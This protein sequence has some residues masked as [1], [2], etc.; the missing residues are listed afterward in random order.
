M[1]G[2]RMGYNNVRALLVAQPSIEVTPAGAFRVLVL[3]A[4]FTRDGDNPPQYWAGVSWLMLNMPGETGPGKRRLMQK[5]LA[6]LQ[7]AG[8]IIRTDK[9]VG[10]R[11]VYELRLP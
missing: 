7:D 1:M 3:M 11:V 6:A 5:Y 4:T 2:Q 9:R 8:W 10:H